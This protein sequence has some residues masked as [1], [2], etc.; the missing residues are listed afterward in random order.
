MDFCSIEINL[1]LIPEGKYEMIFFNS[2]KC[3]KCQKICLPP[4]QLDDKDKYYCYSCASLETTDFNQ[5][6]FSNFEKNEILKNINVIC[7]Y[8]KQGC[9]T[10]FN[11]NQALI[12][13]KIHLKDCPFKQVKCE[14]CSDEF[15]KFDYDM[16]ILQCKTPLCKKCKLKLN[17]FEEHDCIFSLSK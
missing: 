9:K 14:N 17:E 16:H 13:L 12:E 6:V 5:V 7:E 4:Y 8:N 1:I 10:V 3:I 15:N 2:L 11:Y